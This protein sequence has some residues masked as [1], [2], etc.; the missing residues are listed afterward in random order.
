MPYSKRKTEG[1]ATDS[2]SLTLCRDCGECMSK[3][4]W[5]CPKCG[6]PNAAHR[7]KVLLPIAVLICLAV[8]GYFV[9]EWIEIYYE[10]MRLSERERLLQEWKESCNDD[11]TIAPAPPPPGL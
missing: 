7:R 1:C 3:N 10:D 8:I 2:G 5:T 11:G 9:K 6:A 4:A